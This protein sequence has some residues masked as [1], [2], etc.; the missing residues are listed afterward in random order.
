M[1]SSR[2]E[3][4]FS[5]PICLQLFDIPVSLACGHN[6]CK[7]CVER[8]WDVE[9][10]H[11]RFTCP[12]CRRRYAL[13]PELGKNVFIADLVE[14]FKAALRSKCR[15]HT[16]PMRYYCQTHACLVC[17]TCMLVGGHKGCDAITVEEKQ[18]KVKEAIAGENRRMEKEK[19]TE[20]KSVTSLKNSF[21]S[22]QDLTEN[23]RDRIKESF[24]LERRLLD[25]E[26]QEA[27]WG[28]QEKS[29][30]ELSRIQKKIEAHVKNIE[31]LTEDIGNLKKVMALQDSI[32]FLEDDQVTSRLIK[33]HIE[34][35]N[36]SSRPPERRPMLTWWKNLFKKRVDDP[37]PSLQA[38]A[39]KYLLL[40]LSK[41]YGC[42]PTLNAAS[43]HP[44]LQI[45]E[46][47]R[48]VKQIRSSQTSPNESR[49]QVLGYESF[50]SGRRYWEVDVSNCR[51][52]CV[53]VAFK[54]MPH[55]GVGKEC[56]LGQ[57]SM[58][59]C[60]EKDG[61]TIKVLHGGVE[62][63]KREKSWGFNK[64]AIFLDWEA[65]LLSFYRHGTTELLHSFHHHFTQPLVPAVGLWCSE[66]DNNYL[67]IVELK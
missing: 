12:Q 25:E 48:T 22:F 38:N 63:F 56:W 44:H 61:S 30:Q 17:P 49:S 33:I 31:T 58:S 47:R 64:V 20:E 45:S 21:K 67:S 52:C 23:V 5:C 40:R 39:G 16:E 29:R 26:E 9:A 34:E 32:A 42:S 18:N 13:K 24:A 8:A 14:K 60:L 2:Q 43:S 59:W 37:I 7:I 55:N 3:D 36:A 11:V 54:T 46:D 57:N 62:F 4:D 65:R 51:K 50:S 1:A 10:V 15:D 35:R 19:T 53:G 28:V 66:S 27:L 41:S 6:F